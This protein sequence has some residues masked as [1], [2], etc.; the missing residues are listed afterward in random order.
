[1]LFGWTSSE[2]GFGPRQ[3]GPK[4]ENW[5]A[6]RPQVGSRLLTDLSVVH[7]IDR[8]LQVLRFHEQDR[9]LQIVL[10]LAGD[11]DLLALYLR[12]HLQSLV[13]DLLDQGLGFVL[14]DAH[15]EGHFAFDRYARSRLQLPPIDHA[16]VDAA[17]DQLAEHDLL[18]LVH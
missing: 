5:F 11:P 2:E 8:E 14:S 6:S 18:D 9:L 10:G 7:K 17:L 4:Q 3:R 16:T 1:M 13:L 12:L 15:L